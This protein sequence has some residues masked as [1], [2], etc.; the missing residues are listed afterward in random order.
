M[1]CENHISRISRTN[2]V[3]FIWQNVD[4]GEAW[5]LTEESC[6]TQ[7]LCKCQLQVKIYEINDQRR[8]KCVFLLT[9]EAIVHRLSA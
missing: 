7:Y 8:L 5:G 9:Q 2:W 3:A 4:C 1:A 6:E